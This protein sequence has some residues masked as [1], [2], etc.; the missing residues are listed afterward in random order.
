MNPYKNIWNGCQAFIGLSDLV[1]LFP[2]DKD[3]T[4]MEI[5]DQGLCRALSLTV[6]RKK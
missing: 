5:D 3:V 2:G 6:L 1:Q 4:V